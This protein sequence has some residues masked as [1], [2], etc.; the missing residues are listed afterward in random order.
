MMMKNTRHNCGYDSQ[1]QEYDLMPLKHGQE[2]N[3]MLMREVKVKLRPNDLL[4]EKA[5][6]R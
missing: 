6:D 2:K 5:N 4:R 3:G 1:K